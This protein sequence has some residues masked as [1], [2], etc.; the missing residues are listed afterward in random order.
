M[1]A[2]SNT[3]AYARS[4]DAFDAEVLQSALSVHGPCVVYIIRADAPSTAF[5]K[6]QTPK[7]CAEALAEKTCGVTLPRHKRVDVQQVLNEEQ[8]RDYLLGVAEI[9]AITYADNV[10][11][12]EFL[13]A[14]GAAQGIVRFQSVPFEGQEVV[15]A[16]YS[17]SLQLVDEDGNEVGFASP[18]GSADMPSLNGYPRLSAVG[19]ESSIDSAD[20]EGACA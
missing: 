12:I 18:V 11:T 16:D 6:F 10:T 5:I 1:L 4:P 2:A 13:T 9:K 14:I 3:I 7:A 17:P 15:G 19:A 20:D 8:V